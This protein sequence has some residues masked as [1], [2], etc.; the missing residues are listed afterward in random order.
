MGLLLI[1]YNLLPPFDY[2]PEGN[3]NQILWIAE[4]YPGTSIPEIIEMSSGIR[5]FLREQPEVTK[6][7]LVVRPNRKIIGVYLKQES[8]TAKNVE[9]MVKRMQA[10]SGDFAGIA[11]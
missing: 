1:S 10:V 8:A 2:L 11:F 5:S 6:N 3:R 7:M 4:P 9:A